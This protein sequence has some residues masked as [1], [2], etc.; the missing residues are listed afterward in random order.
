[1]HY[2]QVQTMY[3]WIQNVLFISRHSIKLGDL[4]VWEFIQNLIAKENV[5]TLK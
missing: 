3:N 2:V 5:I 1:M 4:K